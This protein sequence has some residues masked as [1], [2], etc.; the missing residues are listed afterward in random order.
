MRLPAWWSPRRALALF[1]LSNVAFLAVDILLAHRMNAFAHPV[2]WLPVAFSVVATAALVPGAAG[3]DRTVVQ[4]AERAVGWL[5]IAVGVSGM[6][7]HLQSHFFAVQ[8]LRSLVYSAPFLA[9]VSYAGVGLLVLLGRS[10]DPSV[11][12]GRPGFGAWITVLAL[13]GFFGNFGL[14]ILDHAQNGFFH[15]TEWIPVGAAALAIGILVVT[16]AR[17]SPEN[18]RASAVVMVLQAL[19]GIAGFVLHNVAS[20][21]GSAPSLLERF[22]YGAPAFAPLLFADLA[23]LAAIGLWATVAARQAET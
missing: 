2:E 14:S 18:V 19:V 12:P 21:R 4:W 15:P 17:P 7:F 20:Y 8:T 10:D 23:L 1:A 6:I 16:L 22:V 3:S 9:P 13:G 5:S 11:Q